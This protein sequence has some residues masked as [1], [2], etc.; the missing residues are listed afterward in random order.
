MTYQLTLLLS[1]SRSAPLFVS[2]LTLGVD[3]RE[4]FPHSCKLYHLQ[5]YYDS[6]S[7]EDQATFQKC[8][9]TGIDNADSGLGCYAMKPADYET[10]APFFDQVS[11]PLEFYGNA[12]IHTLIPF[13]RG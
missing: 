7:P 1:L 11:F 6:L 3:T 13:K 2:R 10:F 4:Q 12:L 5:E 9:R 8:V